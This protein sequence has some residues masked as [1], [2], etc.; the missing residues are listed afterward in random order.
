[1]PFSARPA[2]LFALLAATAQ[3]ETPVVTVTATRIAQTA[4]AVTAAVTVIDRAE[5]ERTQAR[6]LAGLLNGR[7]GLQ[8]QV[9]G[10]RGKIASAFV[11]GTNSGHVLVLVDGV[12]V[13][14]PGLGTISWQYL[15]LAE[16]ERI[17]IVRG[18]RS[19]LYGS[20]AIGG[21]IQIFTRG[22][23]SGS[24][25]S[26][27]LS[28]GAGSHDTRQVAA[29]WSE[30]GDGFELDLGLSYFETAGFDATIGNHPDADGFEQSSLDL[31]LSRGFG[32]YGALR[33]GLLRTEGD[34]EYDGWQAESRYT[35]DFTQQVLNLDY[36]LPVSA[37]WE[38]VWQLGEYR[39]Q[40]ADFTDGL[41]GFVFD[42]ERRQAS[43]QHDLTLGRDNLLNL[44]LDWS[45][46]RL[47]SNSQYSR[48]RR[49]NRAAFVQFQGDYG[50]HRVN[51]A[52]RA[53]DNQSFGVRRTG[54]LAWGRAWGGVDVS[55]SYATAFK[56]PT[57]N[58]LYYIDPWGSSGNPGLAPEESETFELGL[59][60]EAGVG[61]WELRLFRN[62]VEQLIQWLE[63]EP[64]VW[65][66]DNVAAARIDGLEATLNRSWGGWS[67]S[68]DL[69]LLDAKDRATG[70]RLAR[71]AERLLRLDLERTL[72]DTRLGLTWRLQGETYDDADNLRRLSGHGLLDLRIARALTPQ[73]ELRGEL[74]NALNH[75]YQAP[76]GYRGA[77]RALFVSLAYAT[78]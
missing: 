77:E 30:S 28:L 26:R 9:S 8:L 34:N 69:T 54:H 11:R 63:T 15:P 35:N 37:T 57:F 1:M 21:V 65:R 39:E 58:D 52:F 19:H 62:E 32:R 14:S 25:P 3:A 38:S 75:A 51:A 59:R 72:G 76:A 10:G 40:A 16:I 46:E 13:G 67:L 42:T 41:R 73:W 70:K 12:R 50:A 20:D 45:E 64:W 29:G 78:R 53:D 48:T 4:D 71:R 31:G 17:E 24:G 56:A 7:A 27:R 61:R 74:S 5:I 23:G 49:D 2:L 33:L 6:D 43:W 44:G 22:S 47:A 60:G 68:A 18:P 55:L 66:P 36:R